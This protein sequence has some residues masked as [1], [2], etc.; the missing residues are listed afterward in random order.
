MKNGPMVVSAVLALAVGGML[1]PAG[2]LAQRPN[3]AVAGGRAMGS[4]RPAVSQQQS[5]ANHHHHPFVARPFVRP[6]VRP[7]FP[8]AIVATA[9]AVV[10]AAPPAYYAPYYAPP[11]SY[12]PPA[13]YDPPT[14][15]YSPP[16]RGTVSIAP[17]PT[18]SVV[19]YPHGRYELRGD[20]MTVP[21]R[22]L[23]IPN[24]PPPPPVAPPPPPAEPSAAP[25]AGAPSS[26]GPSP[27][28]QSQL[29]RWTDALGV[30]HWTDRLDAVPEQ[31]RSRA[32]QSPVS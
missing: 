4:G 24:P 5:F 9:P 29:Y 7:F 12:A 32:K 14:T 11:V 23:W 6:F 8:F 13:Y 21:Y 28:R 3:G 30:V 2:A 27:Q 18:E 17:A 19:Q 25:P 31:Y 20:G 22:W 1:A 10:Y 16:P 15:Y 26:T